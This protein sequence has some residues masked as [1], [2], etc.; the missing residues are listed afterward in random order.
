[1]SATPM[2]GDAVIGAADVPWPAL[3][4]ATFGLDER[5][6]SVAERKQAFRV[7]S[8][9]WHP[10]RFQQNY[11]AL[12]ADGEREAIMARVTEVSQTINELFQACTN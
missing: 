11:G 12:L 10:D 4:A 9:R 8:L 5:H 3:D 7:A 1:M 2:T 6:S